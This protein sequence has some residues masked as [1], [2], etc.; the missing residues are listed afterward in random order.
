MLKVPMIVNILMMRKHLYV[1]NVTLKP[2]AKL[3]LEPISK[4]FILKCSNVTSAI[5]RR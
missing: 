5:T 2:T 4:S 1:T 3:T